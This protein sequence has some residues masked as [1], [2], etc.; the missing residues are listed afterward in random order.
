MRSGNKAILLLNNNIG[1]KM[2]EIFCTQVGGC[3]Q[4]QKANNNCRYRKQEEN[5][6]L[7]W[8]LFPIFIVFEYM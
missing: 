7:T 2:A 8:E 5:S 1:I 6:N 4:K 3:G